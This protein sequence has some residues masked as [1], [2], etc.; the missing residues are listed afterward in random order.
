MTLMFP[1]VPSLCDVDVTKPIL[2]A[3][4]GLVPCA[5]AGAQ[6]LQTNIWVRPGVFWWP[7]TKESWDNMGKS[8]QTITVITT[9][10]AQK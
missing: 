6:W 1:L 5:R 4:Y 9:N 8:N 2:S 7:G 10:N 3:G